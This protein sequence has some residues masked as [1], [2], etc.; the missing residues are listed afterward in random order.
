[1]FKYFLYA[2]K[3]TDVEDKQ[4]RSIEDQLSVL[5]KLAH[6]EGLNIVKEFVEKQSAKTPGR[7]IFNEMLN[8]TEH[9]EAQGILCWKLDRLARNP[10]DGGQISWFL[11]K[12]TIQHIRTFEKNYYPTDNVLMMSVEFGMANQ[13]ILDL[14]TNTKRGMQ[15]KAKRGEFPGL[16]PIGYTNN[17]YTKTIQVH[18]KEAKAIQ[19]AFELYGQNHSTLEDIALFLFERDIKTKA[20]LRWQGKGSRPLKRDQISWILSNPFYC[21]LFRYNQELYQGIHKP[22]I[23]KK[24]FDTV[25]I[26][27]QQ[28]GKTRRKENNP[29]SLC[30]L[31]R[32]GECDRMITAE[33]HTKKSGLIFTYYR[34]TKKKVHCSQPFIRDTEL[35][36]QLSAI[37]KD[38]VMPPAWATELLTMADADAQTGMQTATVFVQEL[39]STIADI[40]RKLERLLAVY[41]DQDIDREHY[42]GEKNRLTSEKKTFS[43]EIF[44]LE[45][46]QNVWLE[47]LREWLKGAQTLEQIAISPSQSE[48]KVAAQNICGSNLFLVSQKIQFTPQTQWAAL[49][50][51]LKK[52]SETELNCVLVPEEGLEPSSLAATDLKSVAYANSATRAI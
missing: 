39:W 21:G 41:I 36:N 52:S 18:T 19:Q 40:D 31:F 30:G 7:P 34:C 9:G 8:K 27:L 23:S 15:E 29:K 46:K 4:V 13:Y 50:A 25:Q 14:S 28:R 51:A 6:E 5:R 2:R 43:E 20:T 45:Q 22:I 44:H 3:S 17:P 42:L 49:R 26:V 48:K 32:C 35:E 38:F 24:L 37:L 1:M 16:A 12:G 33:S 11:Q 10:I 47:P